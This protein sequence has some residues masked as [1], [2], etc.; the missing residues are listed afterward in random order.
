MLTAP[1]GKAKWT[2]PSL[3]VRLPPPFGVI[4]AVMIGLVAIV[5]VA[6][7]VGEFVDVGVAEAVAEA[8]AVLVGVAAGVPVPVEVDVGVGVFVE[9]GATVEVLV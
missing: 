6:D 3:L 7:T 9:V 4:V 8:L 5:G 1:A 2:F